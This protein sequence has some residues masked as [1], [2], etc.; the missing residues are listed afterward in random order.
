[1]PCIKTFFPP[2][3][4]RA[5]R[6]ALFAH[7][8]TLYYKW[9]L[10]LELKIKSELKPS[11]WGY[12][13]TTI[14]GS[15]TVLLRIVHALP[16]EPPGKF[17][18]HTLRCSKPASFNWNNWT[19]KQDCLKGWVESVQVRKGQKEGS[20]LAKLVHPGLVSEPLDVTLPGLMVCL[21]AAFRY[22]V[23]LS[24]RRCCCCCC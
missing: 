5:L 2:N 10:I 18:S 19:N 15:L 21:E 11:L 14:K 9:S 23:S 20:V 22:P 12:S 8:V 1:M 6:K 17:P 7:T 3:I 4:R 24:W 13:A 16:S